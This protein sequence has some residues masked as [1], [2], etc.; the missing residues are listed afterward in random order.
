MT[1]RQLD[2]LALMNVAGEPVPVRGL[3]PIRGAVGR[4][5]AAEVIE[6]DAVAVRHPDQDLA[7]AVIP[8]LRRALVDDNARVLF[9]EE[10]EGQY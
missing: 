9:V 2:G 8:E 5:H 10:T 3:T 1:P 4:H 6:L 7:V